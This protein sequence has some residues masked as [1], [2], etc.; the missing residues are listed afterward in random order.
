MAFCFNFRRINLHNLILVNF[1]LFYCM[2]LLLMS[3]MYIKISLVLWHTSFTVAVG[4]NGQQQ[5]Q[6]AE[7][8]NGTPE[9]SDTENE[10]HSRQKLITSMRSPNAVRQVSKPKQN[11]LTARRKVIRLLIAIVGSFAAC[12]LPHHVRLL[13][14]LW[15]P[16]TFHPSFLQHLV[17]PTTF[18]F[19]YL[20]SALNPILYAFLSDNFRKRLLEVFRKRQRSWMVTNGSSLA[21]SKHVLHTTQHTSCMNDNI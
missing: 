7:A 2:P 18:L 12:M 17:P 5:Q 3:A 8:R 4:A 20:N 19:F 14:E 1:V 10:Q 6:R 15:A 21:L 11:A 16:Q 13:Y 9:R